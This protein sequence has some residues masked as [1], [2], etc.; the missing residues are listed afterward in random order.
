MYK[1]LQKWQKGGV[2]LKSDINNMNIIIRVVFLAFSLV[3]TT[4]VVANPAGLNCNLEQPPENSGED[5]HMYAGLF[6]IYPR[7]KNIQK[8]YSGCQLTWQA[9]ADGKKLP[10]IW[11]LVSKIEYK[12]GKVKSVV[13]SSTAQDRKIKNCVYQE[14]NIISGD[15]CY[16]AKSLPLKSMAPG[17]FKK[18][19]KF[20]DRTIG[21]DERI[22]ISKMSECMKYE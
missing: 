14:G 9:K 22:N 10:H 20:T 8:N 18:L 2:C 3:V 4:I 21:S 16:P 15:N 1:H 11:N 19:L 12:N 7:A 6:K 5:S 17:C 13:W